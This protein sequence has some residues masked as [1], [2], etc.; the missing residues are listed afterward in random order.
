M[1]DE[2]MACE[3]CDGSNVS[4]DTAKSHAG[5][6]NTDGGE[7]Y[8]EDCGDRVEIVWRE[9]IGPYAH[10]DSQS[11]MARVLADMDPDDL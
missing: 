5:S 2:V 6:P 8:C 1:T 7:Y 10:T 11:G 3:N 9:P 4:K